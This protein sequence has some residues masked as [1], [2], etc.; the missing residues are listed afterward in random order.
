MIDPKKQAD[1]DQANA[2][3]GETLP[4][5]WWKLF[6]NS[7]KLGFTRPEALELVK[8]FVNTFTTKGEE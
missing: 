2:F 1:W 8:V 6:D 5:L 3:L 4:Q 7:V